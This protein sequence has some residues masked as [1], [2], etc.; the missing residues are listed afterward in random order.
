MITS[1]ISKMIRRSKPDR[2]FTLHT[3]LNVIKGEC[4]TNEDG[5]I[6][7][8]N[9]N[10]SNCYDGFENKV[11]TETI[12]VAFASDTEKEELEKSLL[13]TFKPIIE[14]LAMQLNEKNVDF[15]EMSNRLSESILNTLR[16]YKVI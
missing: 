16:E 3:D 2:G 1:L 15:D 8:V 5:Y 10:A 4:S 11:S 6:L 12:I 14:D 13:K 9:I 7:L